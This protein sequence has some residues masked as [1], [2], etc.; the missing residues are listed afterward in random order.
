MIIDASE[1]RHDRWLIPPFKAGAKER[2]MKLGPLHFVTNTTMRLMQEMMHRFATGLEHANGERERLRGQL[3]LVTEEYE[4][5]LATV[6]DA[7]AGGL[8]LHHSPGHARLAT[9]WIVAPDQP[10]GR[11][12]EAA[13]RVAKAYRRAMTEAMAPAPGMWDKAQANNAAFLQSMERDD[14]PAVRDQLAGMFQTDL[15]W[16]LGRVCAL[17]AS[18]IRVGVGNVPYRY[19]FTDLLVSL[20]EAL[21][22]TRLT[23]AEQDAKQ[24][25]RV[26]DADMDETFRASAKRLGVDLSFPQVGGAYGFVAADVRTSSDMMNHAYTLHRL[27]ELGATP[28]DELVEIGG[29]FGCLGLIMARAGFRKYAIYDLPWVNAIQGYFLIMS[30]PPGS[31]RLLGEEN[32]ELEIL[33]FWR[34]YLRPPDSA[35]YV[36]NANSLPEMGVA[37]ARSYVAAIHRVARKLFLSI[38]Q[39]AKAPSHDYGPQQCVA[40]LI[41]EHGGYE[42]L[43]RQ[44]YWMRPGYA[45]EVFRPKR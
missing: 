19:Q 32:G 18:Q 43:S 27:R 36:V 26:L 40:E 30:L 33:P 23:N 45:E 34:F 10:D 20:A 4:R 29:G 35:D 25:A 7:G 9:P 14:L 6:A 31:V 39:E 22:V 28:A 38:N 16:G 24:H 8:R 17:V 12:L 1:K 5:V 3:A 21:G 11:S 13:A 15:V 42:R 41:D 44:R 2:A 37:T